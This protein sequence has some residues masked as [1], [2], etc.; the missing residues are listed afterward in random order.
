MQTIKGHF[1]LLTDTSQHFMILCI[2]VHVVISFITEINQHKL[3]GV[4][5]AFENTVLQ[6]GVHHSSPVCLVGG[7]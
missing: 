2:T 5:K 1:S 6:A 4:S 7:A 3:N